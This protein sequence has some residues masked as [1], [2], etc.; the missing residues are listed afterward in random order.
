MHRKSLYHSKA[1]VP[2]REIVGPRPPFI[3]ACLHSQVLCGGLQAT[4]RVDDAM[5]EDP[6]PEPQRGQRKGTKR[7]I[8]VLVCSELHI[9]ALIRVGLVQPC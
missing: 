6:V 9:M 2:F 1:I 8:E 3:V 4:E 5:E 7:R